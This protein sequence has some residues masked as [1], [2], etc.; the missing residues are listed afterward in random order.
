MSR[1]YHH[2]QTYIILQVLLGVKDMSDELV[3]MSLHALADMVPILGGD[4]V[5]GSHRTRI[6]TDANPNVC[7]HVHIYTLSL[8]VA[9][10]L[11]H[12]FVT[13]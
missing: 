10:R 4:V 1:L 11:C 7:K 6:F 9:F 5:I 2:V 3:A 12:L 8:Q 13:H